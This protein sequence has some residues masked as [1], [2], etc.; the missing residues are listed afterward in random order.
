MPTSGSR[1]SDTAKAQKFP[2]GKQAD[3]GSG[4]RT[5]NKVGGVCGAMEEMDDGRWQGQEDETGNGRDKAQ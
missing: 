3:K 4:L 1:E 2:R 5:K